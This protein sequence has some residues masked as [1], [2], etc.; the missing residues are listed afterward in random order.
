EKIAFC[1]VGEGE[2]LPL[3]LVHGFCEDS[4]M[5]EEWQEFIP[6]RRFISIDLPGFGCSGL[7]ENLTISLMGE[8][9]KA[10]LGH[11]AIEKCILAGHSMG[12]YAS[13][14]FAEKYASRLSG[15]CLFHS[16]PFADSE[17]KKQGRLKAID[18]IKKNGH[19][20]FVRRLIPTLFAYDF[21]KGYQVEV[22]RLIHNATYYSSEAIIAALQA[23]RLRPDR[24]EVLRCIPCPVLF[25][26]GKLDVAIPLEIS[27]EQTYLPAVA[28][29]RILNTTG[30]MGMFEAPRETA[31]AMREFLNSA[32]VLEQGGI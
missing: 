29:I 17:E 6:N 16:H 26:I 2:E 23:M 30:H 8:A 3:V 28:D 24:S 1:T 32:A 21:S 19:I 11:L 14:A 13:L 9:I 20:L 25:L 12:G 15:L 4:R 18:F 5:W 31:K 7:V 27:L 22:N 10:V